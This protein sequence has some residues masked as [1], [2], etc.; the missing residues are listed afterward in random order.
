MY[1]VASVRQALLSLPVIL[2]GYFYAGLQGAGCQKARTFIARH[3]HNQKSDREGY[4]VYTRFMQWTLQSTFDYI[5]HII[6][7]ILQISYLA[8]SSSTSNCLLRLM[9]TVS[10]SQRYTF[11][12][13]FFFFFFHILDI[14]MQASKIFCVPYKRNNE[15]YIF[16]VRGTK[17]TEMKQWTNATELRRLSEIFKCGTICE[18]SITDRLILG[19]QDNNVQSII[20]MGS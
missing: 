5:I 13:F 3:R 2:P 10:V 9:L 14:F 18:T 4:K 7:V 8:C 12:R 17:R 11:H 15:R 20:E 6:F 19:I 16:F 1:V